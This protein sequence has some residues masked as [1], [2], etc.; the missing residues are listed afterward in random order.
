[1]TKTDLVVISS[2]RL[3]STFD[4][5]LVGDVTQTSSTTYKTKIYDSRVLTLMMNS[6]KSPGK[7]SAL[8]SQLI[9]QDA[10][11]YDPKDHVP[12]PIVLQAAPHL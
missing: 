11:D 5:G 4:T 10:D 8:F 1:M 7:N 9:S 6:N 12:L 2:S 3:V